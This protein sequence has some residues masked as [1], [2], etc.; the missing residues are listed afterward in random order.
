MKEDHSSKIYKHIREEEPIVIP[1]IEEELSI[2][3]KVVESAKVK[4]SKTVS[5]EQVTLTEPVISEELIVERISVNKMQETTPV[6]R[7]EGNKT[8][9]PVIKEVLVVE[10][11]IVL[12]EEIHVTRKEVKSY[13]KHSDTIRKEEIQVERF[14]NPDA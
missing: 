11:K 8:I 12:V 2:G 6:V 9:I 10:K 3:K 14:K 7:H 4:I 1:V 13:V 5:E